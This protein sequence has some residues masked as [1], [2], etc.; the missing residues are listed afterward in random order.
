MDAQIAELRKYLDAAK[1]K[2]EQAEE[3]VKKATTEDKKEKLKN[4]KERINKTIQRLSKEIERL[5]QFKK[6]MNAR[7]AKD[8]IE[9]QLMK[10]CDFLKKTGATCFGIRLFLLRGTPILLRGYTGKSNF[11]GNGEYGIY[12]KQG[13]EKYMYKHEF[14]VSGKSFEG[15]N[16]VFWSGNTNTFKKAL[17]GLTGKGRATDEQWV[18]YILSDSSDRMTLLQYVL[19]LGDKYLKRLE[20]PQFFA[21]DIQLY[22]FHRIKGNTINPSFNGCNAVHIAVMYERFEYMKTLLQKADGDFFPYDKNFRKEPKDTDFDKRRLILLFNQDTIQEK[23]EYRGFN[24]LDIAYGTIHNDK[25][26]INEE[27]DIDDQISN[28]ETTLQMLLLLHNNG[29]YLLKYR[30]RQDTWTTLVSLLKERKGLKEKKESGWVGKKGIETQIQEN[31]KEIKTILPIFRA[32]HSNDLDVL[33]T[34]IKSLQA[35]QGKTSYQE[36]KPL[37]LKF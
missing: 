23:T 33:M 20:I 17:E 19:Y 7:I 29:C 15:L 32:N 14:N 31:E 35:N 16:Q 11:Y 30:H 1:K 26:I 6:E 27:K 25:L 2:D 13:V 3:M 34:Y 24:V 10:K 8:I 18:K 5:E 4:A 37:Y 9:L 28:I 36:I 12:K 22:W 21:Y